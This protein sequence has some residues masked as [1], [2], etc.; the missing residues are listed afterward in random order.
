MTEIRVSKDFEA[1]ALTVAAD[2][3]VPEV[4]EISTNDEQLSATNNVFYSTVSPA[5]LK[6]I[7][8]LGGRDGV[9]AGEAVFTTNWVST[10]WTAT[11]L[12]TPSTV[13]AQLSGLEASLSGTDPGFK[14]A[15]SGDFT[16][17]TGS[18]MVGAGS[19][20]SAMV[21]AEHAVQYQY[22]PHQAGAPRPAEAP[23][24]LGAMAK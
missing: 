22:V 11:N 7:A 14:S 5:G 15:A 8:M 10:G 17:A 18:M 3:D 4:F 2:Y 19:D 20:M 6:G 12:V 13:S 24:T 9:T 21:P 23:P 1:L 16:P